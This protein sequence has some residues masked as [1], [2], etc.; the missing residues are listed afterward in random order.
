[1]DSTTFPSDRRD[2]GAE[3]SR[4]PALVGR[5]LSGSLRVLGQL[6]ETSEGPIYRAEYAMTGVEVTLVLLRDGAER[7]GTP[8]ASARLARLLQQLRRATEIDHPNVAAVSGVDETADGLVYVIFE[9]LQGVLLAEILGERQAFP[10]AEAVHLVLQAAAGLQAVHEAGL[11][12]GNLSPATI[13]VTRTAD[14]QRL[15]KLIRFALASPSGQEEIERA[16]DKSAS[17]GYMNALYG[18]PERLA[19]NPPDAQGDI[20]SLGAVLHHL[21]TGA[22]PGSGLTAAKPVPKLARPVL[23]KALAASPADRFETVAEFAAALRALADRAS[24]RRLAR[25]VIAAGAIGT[26]V[27]VALT[28]LWFLWGPQQ[29]SPSAPGK[30]AV[31]PGIVVSGRLPGSARHPLAQ[32][33][34]TGALES[35][36]L[37]ADT[38]PVAAQGV[39]T[40]AGQPI[41]GVWRLL[42]QRVGQE[43]LRPPRAEGFFSVR[44]GIILFQL[45]RIVGDTSFEFY[46]SGGY[47]GSADHFRYGYDRMVWV[48]RRPTGVRV[49]DTIPFK[50]RR[51]FQAHPVGAGVR[52][53][54]DGDRYVFE[55]LGDTLIYSEES[56]WLR[57]WIRVRPTLAP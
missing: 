11:V 18:S 33:A 21:L 32:A 41:E 7:E 5:A 15:V 56:A 24:G 54:A 2:P 29:Q 23:S 36:Q 55:V 48:T 42:V 4:E 12:H 47:S 20:F 17:A 9:C 37:R 51:V 19:G 40:A 35:A 31:G 10:L 30:A 13:L 8:E 44:D 45:R 3:P 34:D 14:N 38:V 25:T 57:R 26:G 52:Y 22:P 28:A 16:I 27:A 1:M 53:E 50:G 43:V 39:A 46:G 6:G 49:R